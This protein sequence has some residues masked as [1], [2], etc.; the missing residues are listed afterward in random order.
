MVLGCDDSWGI[1]FVM[2]SSGRI[3]IS[4]GSQ[5]R[6]TVLHTVGTFLRL[7]RTSVCVSDDS[8]W[9]GRDVNTAFNVCLVLMCTNILL[10]FEFITDIQLQMCFFF[11]LWEQINVFDGGG[12]CLVCLFL[13]TMWSS[14]TRGHWSSFFISRACTVVSPHG[15]CD[16]LSDGEINYKGRSRFYTPSHHPLFRSRASINFTSIRLFVW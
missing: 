4:W 5:G 1:W 7:P 9:R 6:L 11:Q 14:T 16:S 3:S 8:W 10:V 2:K 12:T 15:S 13:R